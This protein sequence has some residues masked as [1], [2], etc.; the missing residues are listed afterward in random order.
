MS[1]SQ[2]RSVSRAA[3]ASLLI[4]LAGCAGPGPRDDDIPPE[5]ARIPDAVPKVEP[6]ARSGNT[7][8]YTFNGRRYVRLATARGYVEQGLASWYGEPFHGRLTSSGEPYD[9][10]GMTAAHRTLPLPSYVRVTNLDNGRRVIVRVNDRGPFIEDRLIDLSYAAA[11][12]LGIKTNGKARVKVE[13]I[14]PKRCLWPFDW[15]CP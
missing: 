3:L 9:R 10:Y 6:L 1:E 12:K 11:V 4:G 15:F 8:F 14:E 13:G 5:I 2:I 7:P